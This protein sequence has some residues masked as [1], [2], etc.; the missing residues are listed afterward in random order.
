MVLPAVSFHDPNADALHGRGSVRN[1]INSAEVLITSQQI[2]LIAA[3]DPELQAAMPLLLKNRDLDDPIVQADVV[4]KLKGAA[5]TAEEVR[6]G[7]VVDVTTTQESPQQAI[8]VANAFA[9]AFVKYCQT[10]LTSQI[11]LQYGE[12]EQESKDGQAALAKFNAA[13]LK[14]KNDT[15][16]DVMDR[17]YASDLEQVGKINGELQKARVDYAGGRRRHIR[18]SSAM[19]SR[20]PE[21]ELERLKLIDEAKTKD[22]ILKAADEELMAAENNLA[23][24]LAGGMTP[25]HPA[26]KDLAATAHRAGKAECRNVT[27][28]QGDQRRQ[29]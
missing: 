24:L 29:D 14:L 7:E 4:A 18:H 20:R 10:Q 9:R 21:Q 6:M 17:T 15:N 12:I 13:L 25:D 16:F 26:V 19:A 22:G 27:R 11:D 2:P 23:Q 8:A 5:D 28:D 3:H 1:I